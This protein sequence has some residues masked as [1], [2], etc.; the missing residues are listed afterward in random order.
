MLDI[1]PQEY[2]RTKYSITNGKLDAKNANSDITIKL[3]DKIFLICFVFIRPDSPK[4]YPSD[5]NPKNVPM[6]ILVITALEPTQNDS[7]RRTTNSND[8][9]TY[10]FKNI[11]N[12]NQK[13]NFPDIKSPFLNA[14]MLSQK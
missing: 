2:I 14:G 3:H 8:K 12:I 11:K 4:K 5:I 10:P 1:I 9:L 6:I 7:W 13:R